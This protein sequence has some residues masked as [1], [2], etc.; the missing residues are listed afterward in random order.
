MV[1]K[2][3]FRAIGFLLGCLLL[4]TLGCLSTQEPPGA[5]TTNSGRSTQ[6]QD[7]TNTVPLQNTNTPQPTP[8]VPASSLLPQVQALCEA[9]F[10]GAAPASNATSIPAPFMS[11][12]S[13]SYNDTGWVYEQTLSHLEARDAHQVATLVCIQ[14]SR[15]KWGEYQNDA[16]A[17]RLDWEVRLL[18]WPDGA[19]LA[20][21]EEAGSIPR[22]VILS[23]ETAGYGEPPLDA[24]LQYLASA[25]NNRSLIFVE[26]AVSGLAFS[27]EGQVLYIAEMNPRVASYTGGTQEMGIWVWNLVDW[28]ADQILGSPGWVGHPDPITAFAQSGDGR[29]LAAGRQSGLVQVWD[30]STLA[31][32]AT[33]Q[34]GEQGFYGLLAVAFSPDETLL[35]ALAEDKVMVW[36]V[37]T[38][39]LLWQ[40]RVDTPTQVMLPRQIAG[41]AFQPDGQALAVGVRT[42]TILFSSRDGTR[43]GLAAVLSANHIVFSLD[44]KM[45]W[46]SSDPSGPYAVDQAGTSAPKFEPGPLDGICAL[47]ASNDGAYLAAGSCKGAVLIWSTDSGEILTTLTGHQMPVWALAFTP[48]GKILASGSDDRSVRLWFAGSDYPPIP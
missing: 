30:T 19:Q 20:G 38:Q 25:S 47:T 9:A 1:R 22:G 7:S 44:G 14:E 3:R 18:H 28:R 36:Q 31:Q 40:N 41:L 5:I 34:A 13:R 21:W 27:P 43:L 8:T 33:M 32:V 26:K 6:T 11:S 15:V 46:Y 29:W 23:G 42:E 24:L 37:S 16:P 10:A 35:A 45:L 12:I 4:A 2:K 48:D 39:E 17:Y